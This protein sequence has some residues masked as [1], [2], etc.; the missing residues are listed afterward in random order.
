MGTGLRVFLVGEDDSIKRFPLGRYERLFKRDSGE[1]LPEYAGKRVR[2]ALVVL[3]VTNRKPERILR[4]DYGWL[5]FDSEGHIDLAERERKKQLAVDSVPP[6]IKDQEFPQVVDAQHR[7]AKKQY[8]DAFTWTPR[9][10]TEQKIVEA[11]FGKGR[12]AR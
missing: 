12:N 4:I 9:P 2:Y 8:A 7:F 6:A 1:R 3:D 10:E 5:I 11:V